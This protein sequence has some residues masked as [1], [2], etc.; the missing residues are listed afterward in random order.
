MEERKK[1][2]VLID[3]DELFR[4]IASHHLEAMGFDVVQRGDGF[5]LVPLVKQIAPVACVVDMRLPSKDG[6][7]VVYELFQIP[8][9]PKVIGISASRD[10]VELAKE[11][12]VDAVL[13]KPI[14]PQAWS[15]AFA[16]I[17]I[18]PQ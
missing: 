3:D 8:K 17:G 18:Q 4:R 1:S 5:G 15:K 6:M 16:S 14:D 10:Y 2:I 12:K 11:I 7:A 13:T 9:R